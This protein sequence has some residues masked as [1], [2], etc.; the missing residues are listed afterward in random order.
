MWLGHCEHEKDVQNYDG[1]EFHLVLFDELTHFTELQ[2]RRICA[3]LRST[4]ATLPH[5]VRAATNPGGDGHAWVYKRFA[6]WLDP[7]HETPAKPGELLWFVGDERVPR[8]TPLALS[9]T[10][11]PA[12]LEDNPRLNEKEYRSQL[13]QLDPVRR[14][15]LEHGDWHKKPTCKAF[16]DRAKVFHCDTVPKPVRRVRAWDF[17][18]SED[19]DYSAC[20][21]ASIDPT[22]TVTI[23]HAEHRKT[24]PEQLYAWFGVCAANDPKGTEQIIPRDPGQAGKFQVRVFQNAFSSVPVRERIPSG[25]KT[26]RFSPVSA[27]HTTGLVRVLK[28]PWNDAFHEE[29]EDFPLGKHDDLV[30]ATSD[31]YAECVGSGASAFSAAMSKL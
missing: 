5:W 9:R 22:G 28:G 23:E 10:F 24:T 31:A 25:D 4:D 2:Y 21:L 1:F 19:G 20:V 12:R 27:R 8:E 7:S 30:D 11:V 3:R 26:T 15:Q 29:L 6:Q 18:G 14:A 17:A 16:W 13:A